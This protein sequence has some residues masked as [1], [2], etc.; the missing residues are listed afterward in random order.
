[1][2]IFLN[3]LYGESTIDVFDDDVGNE[4]ADERDDEA[5][6]ERDLDA[7]RWW[8]RRLLT[9]EASGCGGGGRGERE[10]D[11]RLDSSLNEEASFVPF[12]I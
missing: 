2:R 6:D 9:D 1:M 11:F 4:W 3:D 5:D 8:R 10:R 7:W 12:L